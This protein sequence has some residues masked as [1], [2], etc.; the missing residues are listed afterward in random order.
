VPFRQ[1]TAPADE[2]PRSFRLY[3]GKGDLGL[4]ALVTGLFVVTVASPKAMRAWEWT[5]LAVQVALPAAF[6]VGTLRRNGRSFVDAHVPA[7]TGAGYL[8]F[9]AVAVASG[10]ADWRDGL[11][12]LAG[13]LWLVFAAVAWGRR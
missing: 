8:V 11:M 12:L 5:Q 1:S 13:V 3:H 7:L 2:G 4:F 10:G 6:V 9:V